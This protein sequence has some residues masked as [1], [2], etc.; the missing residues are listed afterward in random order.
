MSIFTT[1][2]LCMCAFII[3]INSMG[4]ALHPEK[5]PWNWPD[6]CGWL[7]FAAAMIC[8]EVARK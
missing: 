1:I 2:M 8:W 4:T 3:G 6:F 5:F 7:L